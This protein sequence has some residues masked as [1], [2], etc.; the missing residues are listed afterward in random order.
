VQ[1][2]AQRLI[3]QGGITSD[4]LQDLITLC[5]QEASSNLGSGS[6]T[7]PEPILDDAFNLI[8]GVGPLRL[9]AIKNVVGINALAP[10]NPLKFGPEPLTIIYGGNG[11]GKSGYLRLLKH[12][13]GARALSPLLGDV[14]AAS[15]KDQSCRIDYTISGN[16]NE[17]KW[18]PSKGV[19]EDLKGVAIYDTDCAYVYVDEEH[20]VSYEPPLLGLFRELVDAC[21]RINQALRKE[22]ESKVSSLPMLPNEYTETN[23]A[24]WYANI[25]SNTSEEDVASHCAWSDNDTKL[26]NMLIQRLSETDPQLKAKSLRKNKEHLL[27]LIKLLTEIQTQLSDSTFQELLTAKEEA[28][29]KRRAATDDADRIFLN[30]PLDGISSE[31]WRLLW[32]QARQFSEEVAYPTNTF[33]NTDAEARCV[34]CQQLLA[35]DAKDRLRSFENFVKGTLE[36]KASEAEQKVRRISEELTELPDF[37]KLDEMLDLA[38]VIDEAVRKDVVNYYLKLKNRQEQF[39]IE[40]ELKKLPSIPNDNELDCLTSLEITLE[41][42]ALAYERDAQTSDRSE[43]MKQKLEIE[44]RKW[45]YEQKI[46]IENEIVRLRNIDQLEK[47]RKLTNTQAL[48]LKASSLSKELITEALKTRFKDEISLLGAKRIRV[49]IEKVRATKGQALHKLVLNDA[50]IAVNALDILSE[51]E[52]RIISIAAFLAD[53]VTEDYDVPFIFDDPIS[54][55]DQDY[56]ER[57]AKRF[58]NLAHSRQVIIFTHRLSFLFALENAG[59][60]QGVGIRVV[61]LKRESWST[62][63]PGNLPLSAQKPKKALN[64]LLNER[65]TK[66]RKVLEENGRSDY[67]ILAKALCSDIRIT[68]ERLI[69]NDL[70]ADVVQ[71]FR[72]QIKTMGKLRLVAKVTSDDCEFIDGFM[73]K[74]SNYEHSQP[75]DAPIELPEPDELEQDLKSLKAWL[76]EFSTREVPA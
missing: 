8:P 53:M 36:L 13:C 35:D 49:N 3:Q 74:Y 37:E 44:A 18:V 7:I 47:A 14:F 1:D 10:R 57:V 21:D 2:A 4:D 55:L 24:S 64:K 61:P 73:T 39:C 67:D 60:K 12:I 40:D 6:G 25:D 59:E 32:E 22:I 43:L 23:A 68:I 19:V 26:L 56:E 65:L 71:R 28:D 54:S 11:A 15:A 76:E 63:E 41:K 38:G 66:A 5:K 42:Q 9:I 30:A 51:G 16:N 20:E 75:E 72:R 34:L 48:T 70:L 58:V 46:S 52:F 33:P 45:L 27:R 50:K 69:E 29:T 17:L 31:S 62:G